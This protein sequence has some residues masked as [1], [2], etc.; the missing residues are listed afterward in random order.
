MN[1][2]LTL[3]GSLTL[4]AMVGFQVVLAPPE[5]PPPRPPHLVDFLPTT[6]AGFSSR[7]LELGATESV[8]GAVE[9]ILRYDD[10]YYREFETGEARLAVFVAYWGPGKMPIRLVASHTPDRCWTENGW[11]CLET[12]F[13]QPVEVAGIPLQPTEWRIFEIQGQKQY[14]MYWHLIDGRVPA[15]GARF[16]AAPNP[17]HWLRDYFR[18]LARTP[19]EQYF[20]RLN[21]TVPIEQLWHE[22]GFQEILRGLANLGL[23]LPPP[24]STPPPA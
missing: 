18:N 10:V 6:V 20:I 3:L 9:R 1:I 4:L 11:E 21:A 8:Q 2:L 12:R 24:E 23:Q 17:V 14:V 22:P 15:E 7:E 16:N 5:P 13:A 19:E